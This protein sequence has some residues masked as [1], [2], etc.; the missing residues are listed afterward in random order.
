MSIAEDLENEGMLGEQFYDENRRR[1]VIR[2]WDGS[3]SLQL[4]YTK[5]EFDSLLQEELDNAYKFLFEKLK[6]AR[7]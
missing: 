3:S 1:M 6:L 2:V 4:T 7:K 5:K